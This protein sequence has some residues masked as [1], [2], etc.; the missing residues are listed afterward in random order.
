MS[1][2]LVLMLGEGY[3]AGKLWAHPPRTSGGKAI[4]GLE[5]AF[6]LHDYAHMSASALSRV[7][8]EATRVLLRAGIQSRWNAPVDQE[9]QGCPVGGANPHI[10][11]IYVDVLPA[12][13]ASHLDLPGTPLG[14]SLLPRLGQPPSRAAVFYTR[15]LEMAH[16]GPAALDQLL[17]YAIAHEV[18]HLLLRSAAHSDWGIMQAVWGPKELEQICQGRL[19]F[20]VDESAGMRAEL[21][22]RS[23]APHAGEEVSRVKAPVPPFGDGARRGFCPERSADK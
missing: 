4:A 18:G 13:M 10:P 22:D 21:A 20:G 14:Y 9:P 3:S 11:V 17:G 23:K 5:I 6:Q 15:A 19:Y 16:E 2:G 7:E 8:S 1:V 12:G